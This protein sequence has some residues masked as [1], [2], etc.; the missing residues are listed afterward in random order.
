MSHKRDEVS[1]AEMIGMGG[2]RPAPQSM[3]PKTAHIGIVGQVLV[4][5]A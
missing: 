1:H 3:E 4:L 5:H 2:A